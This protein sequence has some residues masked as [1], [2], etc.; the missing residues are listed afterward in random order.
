[1]LVAGEAG[2]GKTTL[3]EDVLAGTAT[4]ALRAAREAAAKAYSAAG[5]PAEAVIDRLAM[6]AHLRSAASYSA[7]LAALSAAKWMPRRPGAP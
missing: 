2:A 5:S 3:V 1:V 6:A 7:A 4:V